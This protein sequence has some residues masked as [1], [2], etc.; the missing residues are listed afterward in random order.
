APDQS[1]TKPGG[2]NAELNPATAARDLVSAVKQT[3][4]IT[5][6][7]TDVVA[8]RPAYDLV[9]TPKADQRTL[10][11]QVRIA[12]DAQT[13]MPLQ[14]TVLANNT[15]TPALQIGFSS[16]TVGAQDPALFRF[17]VPAGATVVNG[18]ANDHTATEMANQTAPT[19]VGKGWE[20]VVVVHLPSTTPQSGQPA[21]SEQPGPFGSSSKSSSSSML[22]LVRQFG[23]PVSGS[24]GSGWVLSTDVGNA[25]ITSDGR[26]A[27]GFV[28]VQL[29]TSALGK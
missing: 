7:G 9:L 12:V 17:T 6:D 14:L 27:V 22:G 16:L 29:L 28:P 20:T 24:W 2:S 1:Q 18:D 13:H 19:L 3:S 26:V 4:T 25:V 8:D 15:D 11:R 23:K 10:L 21:Q 5:V